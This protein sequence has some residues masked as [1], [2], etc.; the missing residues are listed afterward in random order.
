MARVP[1]PERDEHGRG[2]PGGS[3]QAFH[4][5]NS[6]GTRSYRMIL[7]AQRLLPTRVHP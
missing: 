2:A 3:N 1:F 6:Q 5:T 4:K 7:D